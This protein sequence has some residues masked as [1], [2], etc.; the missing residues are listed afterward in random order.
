MR[1][2]SHSQPSLFV[3]PSSL[4]ILEG[5]N[6]MRKASELAGLNL[7]IERQEKVLK[8]LEDELFLEQLR[9][10]SLKA[11]RERALRQEVLRGECEAEA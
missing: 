9:L 8:Q 6:T 3:N 5:I 7:A 2:G 11:A 10:A 1:A 4:Y